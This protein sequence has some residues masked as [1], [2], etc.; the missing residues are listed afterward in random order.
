MG[1]R[2]GKNGV[3]DRRLSFLPCWG[4]GSLRVGLLGGSKDGLAEG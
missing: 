2:D 4:R 1:A 3:G